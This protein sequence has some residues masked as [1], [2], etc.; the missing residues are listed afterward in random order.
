MHYD[1]AMNKMTS[2]PTSRARLASILRAAKEVVSIKLTSQIL[3]I[4]RNA[5][6]K[7]LAR[8]T[9]QGWLRRIG[10]GI[11]VSVP[12]DL[13][14]SEQII[15]D[16]WALVPALFGVCYIGGWTAAH[17]WDLTEQLFNETLIYTANRIPE[18]RVTVQGA[19]FNLHRTTTNRLF[20]M[21]TLWRNS[22]KVSISDPART[23]VDML[24]EP[25]VGGGIDH[26]I[27]CLTIYLSS[28]SADRD[29]LIR[30]AEQFENGAI[31]KRLGFIADT[32]LHDSK[33][34]E[35]SRSR[36]TQ[37]YAKLDPSQPSKNLITSWRL[38]VPPSW[39]QRGS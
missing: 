17:H 24:A 36:L 2:L 8:W 5:A 13:A 35:E 15:A 26:V 22:T 38:W 25:E 39:K 18:S 32:R 11:Y 33:L 6:A 30:Y 7:L 9:E 16:P 37:G 12:L 1:I 10:P 23:L 34:I 28:K 31:F 3:G 4:E 27:D 14:G 21:K 19:A 20:G 29:L